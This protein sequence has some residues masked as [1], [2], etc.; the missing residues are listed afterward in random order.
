M[1]HGVTVEHIAQVSLHALVV[2]LLLAVQ[3]RLAEQ[4]GAGKRTSPSWSA[5]S[6]RRSALS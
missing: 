2:P 4:S 3:R 5:G 1:S 6:D